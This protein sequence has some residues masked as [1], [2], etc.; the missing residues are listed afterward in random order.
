MCSA[1]FLD[2]D[3]NADDVTAPA[4]EPEVA[5]VTTPIV[6]NEMAAAVIKVRAVNHGK[7]SLQCSASL[8][9]K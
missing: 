8:F 4:P 9:A 7:L 3:E 1:V 5:T 6:L 2:K